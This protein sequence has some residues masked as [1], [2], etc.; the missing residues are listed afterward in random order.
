MRRSRV[1]NE[2]R[3]KITMR[4][5]KRVNDVT[6]IKNILIDVISEVFLKRLALADLKFF[7]FMLHLSRAKFIL[8]E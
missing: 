8:T 7:E 1:I 6:R 2:Q 3:Q 4:E 5:K